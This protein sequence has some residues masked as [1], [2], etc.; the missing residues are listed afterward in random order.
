MKETIPKGEYDLGRIQ[1]KLGKN[2]RP[3]GGDTFRESRKS[4]PL[5][6]DCFGIKEPSGKYQNYV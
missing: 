1:I 3:G 6:S 4:R 2:S 5:W